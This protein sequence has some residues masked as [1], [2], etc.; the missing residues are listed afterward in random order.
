MLFNYTILICNKTSN[1]TWCLEEQVSVSLIICNLYGFPWPDQ[2]I[3]KSKLAKKYIYKYAMCKITF[4]EINYF[5]IKS[6]NVFNHHCH[7]TKLR[8]KS[9]GTRWLLEMHIGWIS[10]ENILLE[11]NWVS[12]VNCKQTIKFILQFCDGNKAL[13]KI[14]E[15]KHYT[16]S[17]W[18]RALVSNSFSIQVH[19]K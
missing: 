10:Q 7:F 19:I 17:V 8:I 2:A 5:L 14:A 3:K 11:I 6:L 15:I 16:L 4:Y 12:Y 1:F 18:K 9:S 13:I